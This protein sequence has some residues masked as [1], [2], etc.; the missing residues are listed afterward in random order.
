MQIS[1]SRLTTIF[2]V[3][4]LN[5]IGFGIIIPLLPFYADTF[6]A[7]A[8]QIGLLIA[9]YPAAQLLASPFL[10][11]LSDRFGRRPVLIWTILGNAV[12]FVIFAWAESLT[13]LFISRIASGLMMGNGSVIQAYVADITGEH[14]RATGLGRLGAALGL[15]F[16][17]GPA[18]GGVLAPLGYEAPAYAAAMLSLLNTFAVYMWLPESKGSGKSAIAAISL[19]SMRHALRRPFI[20]TLL[21]V[22]FLFSLAFS[23]FTTIFALFAQKELLLNADQTGYLLAYAGFLIVLVQGIVIERLV[24]VFRDGPL[25]F[26]SIIMMVLALAGW[27]YSSTVLLVV[28]VMIPLTLASGVFRT[29][30]SSSLTK[31]VE[32]DEIGGILGISMSLDSLTRVVAPA[33]GGFLMESIGTGAPALFSAALLAAILPLAWKKF[34]AGSKNSFNREPRS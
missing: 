9:S 34:V 14:D 30:V 10:G 29:I 27:A 33:A 3:A 28:L 2:I 20:S 8:G 19:S 22:R 13:V 1:T 24:R 17:I 4:F 23:T 18:M 21:S 7:D 16:I 5:L 12:A 11:R 25:I 15:G 32:D 6:G 31:T 26:Y